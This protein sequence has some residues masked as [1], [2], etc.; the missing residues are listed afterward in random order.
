MSFCLNL[1]QWSVI[2]G[3]WLYNWQTLFGACLAFA[4]AWCTVEKIREQISLSKNQRGDE[5]ARRHRA[6]RTTLPLT[7]AAVSDVTN[8]VTEN[9]CDIRERFYPDGSRELLESILQDPFP[10]RFKPTKLTPEAISSFEDF[11]ETISDSNDIEHAQEFFSS[12][13]FLLSSYNSFDLNSAG[14]ALR[15][16]NLLLAAA[17]VKLLTDVMFSYA[18]QSDAKTFSLMT[19]SRTVI[20]DKIHNSAQSLVS[21]RPSHDLYFEGF[22]TTIERYKS[23]DKS[24]WVGG[25]AI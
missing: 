6:A 2:V 10:S 17:R 22:R 19:N 4:G 8:E 23:D 20:W 15:L 21:L 7:L 25:E 11:V 5:I 24:P 16:E 1:P 12:L 13:Q 9:V 18:H 14:L 3:N